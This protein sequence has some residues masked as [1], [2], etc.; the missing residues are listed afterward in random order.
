MAGHAAQRRA[1]RVAPHK[2]LGLIVEHAPRRQRVDPNAGAGPIGR[3]VARE[4]EDAAL[5]DGIGDRLIAAPLARRFRFVQSLVRSDQPV[6]R[7]TLTMTPRCSAS[8]VAPLT[9]AQE[10]SG[11]IDGQ[12]A[13]PRSANTV[14]TGDRIW[15]LIS[16]QTMD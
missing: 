2:F 4:A 13:V 3:E 16:R 7:G 14:Q 9:G 6:G 10:H 12:R 5:G 15:R 1:R 8:I 11:Q